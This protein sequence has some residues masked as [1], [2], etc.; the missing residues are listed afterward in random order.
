MF[1]IEAGGWVKLVNGTTVI[2]GDVVSVTNTYIQIKGLYPIPLKDWT[3]IIIKPAPGKT[4]PI[5]K[6]A[7]GTDG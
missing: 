4:T 3:P 7:H 1:E 2:N 6:T 5:R